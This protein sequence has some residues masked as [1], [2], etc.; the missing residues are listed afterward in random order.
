MALG[1]SST[2]RNAQVDAITT[3]VGGSALPSRTS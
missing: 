3:A 1:Y 2:L